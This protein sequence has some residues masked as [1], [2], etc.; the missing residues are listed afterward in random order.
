M[1]YP[2]HSRKT[3]LLS[4]ANELLLLLR[5]NLEPD[6]LLAHACYYLL[7]PRTRACYAAY[8]N[9]PR[10]W[11]SLLFESGL[12]ASC[13][14][15]D[16]SGVVWRRMAIECAEHAWECKHSACGIQRLEENRARLQRARELRD[17]EL[18][19]GCSPL[20]T[21]DADKVAI[22]IQQNPLFE[23][24]DFNS[25]F[26]PVHL[27]DRMRSILIGACAFLRETLDDNSGWLPTDLIGLHPVACRSFATFPPINILAIREDLLNRGKDLIVTNIHGATVLDALTALSTILEVEMDADDI[28]ALVDFEIWP[29]Y[30]YNDWESDSEPGPFP[31]G[32]PLKHAAWTAR[33]V[34]NLFQ[35]AQWTG[36]NFDIVTDEVIA[37]VDFKSKPLPESAWS[38]TVEYTYPK[39]EFA[40]A[41]ALDGFQDL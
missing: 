10:F 28:D 36:F 16:P 19:D 39:T 17:P 6:D 14:E 33:R 32:W 29:E 7:H 3:T 26:P 20:D 1:D 12:A 24:I 31:W 38:H 22:R 5:D 11:T 30:E 25:A 21:T 40:A 2:Y 27:P 15:A 35:L 8:D 37:F 9:D 13:C 34:G 23:W 4:L 41:N 18:W